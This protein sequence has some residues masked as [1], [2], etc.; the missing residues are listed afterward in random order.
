MDRYSRM[1]ASKIT[2]G[3][4]QSFKHWNRGTRNFGGEESSSSQWPNDP[5]FWVMTGVSFK[6]QTQGKKEKQKKRDYAPSSD[7]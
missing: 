3:V 7:Q 6:K 5:V 2:D 1:G 4:G